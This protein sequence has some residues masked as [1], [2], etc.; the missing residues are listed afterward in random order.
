MNNKT[1]VV[2]LSGGVD[3]AVSAFLLKQQGYN[4]IAVFMQNWDPL[5]NNEFNYQ[6]DNDKCDAQID[7]EIAQKIAIQLDIPIY[8]VE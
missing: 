3:S 2:G 6:S 5:M 8:R 7:F 1:V 4:V